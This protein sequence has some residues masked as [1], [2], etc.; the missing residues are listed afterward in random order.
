MLETSS[1]LETIGTIGAWAKNLGSCN[2][3]FGR[4]P[5][6]RLRCP[7]HHCI[8]HPQM[9]RNLVEPIAMLLVR[10]NDSSIV[11]SF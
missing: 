4:G 1:V 7:A 5:S 6:I 11:S 10:L 3:T 9:R 8:T 2:H